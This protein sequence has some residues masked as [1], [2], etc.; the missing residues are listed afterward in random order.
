MGARNSRAAGFGR[1][2]KYSAIRTTV[3]GITF[4]S[5]AEAGFY[6]QLRLRQAAGEISDLELQPRYDLIVNG[7]RIGR[8]T[9]DFRYVEGGKTIVAD[10][11]GIAS[12]D[13]VLRKKLMLA[14]HGIEILELRARPKKPRARRVS[15]G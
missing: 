3:D 10:A 9:G 12:R 6:Q 11:K 1:R 4:D 8:Y 5:K 2:N 15:N 14:L 7:I 13:Y